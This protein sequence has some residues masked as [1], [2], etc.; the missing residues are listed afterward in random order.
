MGIGG[1]GAIDAVGSVVGPGC[2]AGA[3]EAA[4]GVESIMA[5]SGLGGDVGRARGEA[6]ATVSMAG[7]VE[8]ARTKRQSSTAIGCDSGFMG[9]SFSGSGAVVRPIR[10]L[11]PLPQSVVAGRTLPCMSC[12]SSLWAALRRYRLFFLAGG[13]WLNRFSSVF[14]RRRPVGNCGGRLPG[15][16]FPTVCRWWLRW[17]G[18]RESPPELRTLWC[19]SGTGCI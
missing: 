11:H 1:G 14:C 5:A 6:V 3:T 16:P 19:P 7:A 13:G 4:A 12:F 17:R 9:R 10:P 8:T 2:A 15:D 18:S